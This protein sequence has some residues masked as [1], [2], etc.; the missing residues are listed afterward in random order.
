MLAWA[1]NAGLEDDG[2][3]FVVDATQALTAAKAVSLE[4]HHAGEHDPDRVSGGSCPTCG[5]AWCVAHLDASGNVFYELSA[6]YNPPPTG[7]ADAYADV[8]NHAPLADT[9]KLHS[10]PSATKV[11][12]L[13]FT[14]HTTSGTAWNRGAT[15]VTPEYDVDGRTGFSDTELNNIQNI[16]ARVV[17][18]FSPFDV[19]VTTEEPSLDDLRKLGT[20]DD[21]WGIRVV[22]GPDAGGVAPGAGG[23]AYLGSFNWNSDTPTFVFS[24]VL[25]SNKAIAEA[26]SHEVGHTL[27][28]NHDGRTSPSEGY[29]QGHGSGATGWAPIMG[30]GYYREVVQWSKGEYNAANNKED[31]LAIITGSVTTT[32]TQ[33][34][35][36]FTY[37]VD[38]FGSTLA[39]ASVP[40]IVN[41]TTISVAGVIERAEDIDV[42][43]FFTLDTLQATIL[44]AAISPNL[45][46]LAE[47][48]DATGNVLFT[49]NPLDALSAS[50]TQTV[51]AGTYYLAIR[52]T[53]KGDPLTN[54]YSTYASLGQYSVALTVASD[55][56]PPPPPV[57]LSLADDKAP[58]TGPI[59]SGGRTDDNTLTATGT[60]EPASQVTVYAGATVIGTGTTG[61]DGK[62]SVALKALAEGAHALTATAVD[63]AQNVSKAS[64]PYDVVLD[65]TPPAAPTLSSIVDDVAPKV[66]VVPRGGN[67]NDATPT[68]SGTASPATTIRIFNVLPVG[69]TLV[70]SVQADGSGAW[71]ITP[72]LAD[73]SYALQAVAVDDV[74]N[75]SAASES[76]PITIDTTT[77]IPTITS[78][79][80]PDGTSIPNG[81][82]TNQANLTVKGTAEAGSTV[83][84]RSNGV[85]IA[86]ATANSGGTWSIQP[87]AFASSATPYSFTATS[88][89]ADG[90]A[91]SE[92]SRPF[93]V[94][95]DFLPPPAPRFTAV[96]DDVAPSTGTIPTGG[97]TNDATPVMSGL[98][99][100]GALITIKAG[101]NVIG[102]SKVGDDGTWSLTPSTMA[103]GT[104]DLVAI[105]SDAA[106]NVS[107]PSWPAYRITIDQTAPAAPVILGLFDDVTPVLGKVPV[108]GHTN[109]SMLVIEGT[110]EPG[111]KVQVTAGATLI[112]STT[113]NPDGTWS[114]TSVTLADASYRF[115]ATATD[116]VGNV[117]VSSVAYAATVDTV[118][119]PPLITAVVDD[120]GVIQGVVANG[121]ETDD[122]ILLIRGTAEPRS[123]VAVLQSGV[124]VGNVTAGGTGEWSYTTSAL[125]AGPYAF[126][127]T[128]VDLAGNESLSSASYWLTVDLSPPGAPAITE[129]ADDLAPHVGNVR[130]GGVTNDPVLVL[131][132]SGDVGAT[133]R[134]FDEDRF[135][136]SASVS[137]SGVWSFTTLP[138]AAGRHA[139][140]AVAR[141]AAGNE[142]SASSPA[143]VVDVILSTPAP[144]IRSVTDDQL[145][146]VGS[147]PSGGFTNDTMPTIT[148]DAAAGSTVTVSHAGRVLGTA[149]A[150]LSGSWTVVTSPLE[151]RSYAVTATSVDLAGNQSPTSSAYLLIVDATPPAPPTILALRD[152]VGPVTGDVPRDGVTDDRRP[153]VVGSAEPNSVVTVN[154]TGLVSGTAIANATGLWSLTS[155]SDLPDG[156]IEMVAFATDAAG[157]KSTGSL[158][159][160]VTIDLQAPAAPV[161]TDIVD[162]FGI[163]LGSVAPGGSI[164]DRTP[165]IR[166]TAE[167]RGLIVVSL[168]SVVVGTADANDAGRWTFPVQESLADGIYT[169]SARVRDA[170][171]N[172]SADSAD[173]T[174]RLVTK[175]DRPI[176]SRVLDDVGTK[177]GVVRSGE[178][179]DDSQPTVEG[180]APLGSDVELVIR[181][182]NGTLAYGTALVG[183]DGVWTFT[184]SALREGTYEITARARDVAGNVSESSSPPYVVTVDFTAPPVPLFSGVRDDFGLIKGELPSGSRSDDTLP[185]LFG[186][187]EPRALVRI[188][189]G[190]SASG[191][192]VADASGAWTFTTSSLTEGRYVF[193]AQS[194][195]AAGEE[196]G[197]SAPFQLEID[198][199]A[200][201][202]PQIDAVEDDVPEVIGAVENGDWTND[203]RPTIRGIAPVNTR[204]E[205][206]RADASL[207]WVAIGSVTADSKGEWD[208]TP[209]ADLPEGEHVLTAVAR[210]DVGNTSAPSAVRTFTLDSLPPSKPFITLP[211]ANA[212][213]TNNVRPTFAISAEAGSSVVVTIQRAGATIEELRGVVDGD[214]RA[215]VTVESPL[216]DGSYVA[217]V[218]ALDAAGNVSPISEPAVFSIDTMRPGA[219]TILRGTADTNGVVT[220][221]SGGRTNDTSPALFGAA[222]ANSSV[223]V[224]IWQGAVAVR[225]L[226]AVTATNGVFSVATAVLPQGRYSA[227]ATVTDTAGNVSDA[228]SPFD[229]EIDTTP[230]AVPQIAAV[231]DDVLP[232]TGVVANGEPTND[233]RPTVRGTAEA[234]T[235]VEIRRAGR[236]LGWVNADAKGSWLLTPTA[237]L[238]E[239]EHVLTA[240]AIDDVGN[241]SEPSQAISFAVDTVAPGV[242][243]LAYGSGIAN[244]ATLAEATQASGVVTVTGEPGGSVTV[245]FK[246]PAGNVTKTL[247]GNGAAQPVVLSAD[248]VTGLGNG[249]V[250]VR[251]T[252]ADRAGNASP[253]ANATFVIDSTVATLVRLDSPVE[254]GTYRI[255]A[256][257]TL[258]A[259]LSEAVRAGA[260]IQVTLNTGKSITLV[261]ATEGSTLT[262]SYVVA[263][264]DM[265]RDLDVV[266]CRTPG[267]LVDLA[268]NATS[269][270]ALPGPGGRLATLK[271]IVVDGTIRVATSTSFSIDPNVIPDRRSAVTAI[272]ITFSTPVTGVS[273]SAFRLLFNGRSVSLRGAAVLGSGSSYTLRL[274]VALTTPKGF[275]T[276]EILPTFAIRAAE[277][278][279]PLTETLQ[280][281]WGNGRSKGLPAT[282]RALAFRGR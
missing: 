58:L 170:A 40:T 259:T 150:D 99:E 194:V 69:A 222:E 233:R 236:A 109:D 47:I 70:G 81:G 35:N 265:A 10:R 49:S 137:P 240:V 272:P 97:R 140:A 192:T 29:F 162:D 281:S 196:S 258:V 55:G 144:N 175:I 31:D 211:A 275:Y 129:V 122:S 133:V 241:A 244:G 255:G 78:V 173:R 182:G 100:A 36:G 270:A 22:M 250:N 146:V 187:A 131:S 94:T 64:A 271:N 107:E 12:Y 243:G 188:F 59:A 72:T 123:N 277:N 190:A 214:G 39:T 37:R 95:V 152:D 2:D 256:T 84:L 9:F 246:G 242:P 191:S 177:Q 125:Q 225:T 279:A 66:G 38:D 8:P 234:H 216:A 158:R 207:G 54:G 14:G 19:N 154:F 262:G 215:S 89:D 209:T 136:G 20:N 128:Q 160:P 176:I 263:P 138:L 91:A 151:E 229:F 82:W 93:L 112:G 65:M 141:D 203:R 206:R 218:E 210:D 120:M 249:T 113:A 53:G 189:S 76:Y 13:D 67:T 51:S 282:A 74:G 57:I 48:W 61:S 148:G 213:M 174:F 156:P 135:L 92:P 34:G 221:A 45:D 127:A 80:T 269:S 28:L 41:D 163:Y 44:P 50:F 184:P 130:S 102:T 232:R 77:D 224:T 172:I 3:A 121:G 230:P 261:A 119:A 42:F 147:V 181:D 199:T 7:I 6:P 253:S 195:N 15:F 247:T 134:V 274:P 88:V 179:T 86:T 73:G 185:T 276:L 4:S 239:G 280:I 142:S 228:S 168:N 124:V 116:E 169:V 212:G 79:A 273:L 30:V 167:P 108:D 111:S 32:Y 105:A 197:L 139:F 268:G 164:D 251:V 161:I 85:T 60:A 157:N 106:G 117:S 43:K 96:T 52:G 201:A 208:L 115:I 155:P 237:D 166:G 110:A 98:A 186:T 1:I 235:R 75:S 266:A 260:A 104:Y 219:P 171:G 24:D 63:A 278:S 26:I 178:G 21:R 90:N 27:G 149:V 252:Q 180:T 83:T 101:A 71:T 226:P 183:T 56:T 145:P 198:T 267:P 193:S 245:V 220:F 143:Y 231:E 132:G 205:I 257:I 87:S 202:V 114:L 223:A 126:T 227:T 17:E 204:V 5:S 264:G 254:N 11:I 25:R 23:V 217:T 238:S 62:W 33:N 159:Y 248:E 18:D 153:T 200:P 16:W 46:I 68:L 165:T 103:D 118:A